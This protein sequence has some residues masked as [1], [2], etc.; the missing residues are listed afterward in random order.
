MENIFNNPYSISYPEIIAIGSDDS[1]K[2]ELIEKFDCIGGAMWAGNHY[3]KSPLTESVRVVGN[4][5]RFMLSTGCVDLE[6]EGSY[7]PA[8]ICGA[9]ISGDEIE[10]SY[11]GMGGGGVGAS[12]C[13]S[14]AKGVIKSSSEPCGGGK[15]AGSTITLPKMQRVVIGIDDTDTA[16]EGATWTLA[17]NISKAVEDENSRYLSHTIVQLFPVPYRTKNCVAIACEFATREPEKL[18]NRFEELVR[19]Y[20]LSEETGL[21]AFSGFD[22]SPLRKYG[23]QVKAGEVGPAE[24]EEIRDLLEIRIEGRGIIGAAAA[25]PFY[26]D[27]EEALKI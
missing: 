11:K 25:I 15:V 17:H 18:M 6:L 4:T 21:C 1:S 12:V 27:Y 22:T 24:F 3:R 10:I 20:T 13:R 26:T 16:E 7:F 14:T 9:E 23:E 5:Q 2:I 8:G 19:K